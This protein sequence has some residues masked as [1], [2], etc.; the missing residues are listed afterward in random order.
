MP[1]FAA[2]SLEFD[3]LSEVTERD[4]F[5]EKNRL[6]LNLASI[7][8]KR[9]LRGLLRNYFL[10]HYPNSKWTRFGEA[11]IRSD[12]HY[13]EYL[14][15]TWLR[16]ESSDSGIRDKFI[17]GVEKAVDSLVRTSK[18]NLTY[19]GFDFEY[20]INKTFT[21]MKKDKMSHTTCYVGMSITY[22]LV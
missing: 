14:L 4:E 1:P 2:V 10:L 7:W 20:Y 16:G 11:I 9:S 8:P 15:K 12:G 19:V 18:G 21:V 17:E 22:H 5:R 3:Y 6:A 13:L